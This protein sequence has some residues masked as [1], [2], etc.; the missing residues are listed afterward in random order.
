MIYFFS[1]TGNSEYVAERL[2]KGPN[3][4]SLSLNK[5]VKDNIDLDVTDHR[6]IIVTPTYAWRIPQIVETWIKKTRFRYK[7]SMYFV[8]TCGDDIGNASTYNKELCT[9]RDIKYM[10]TTQVV[11]PENYIALFDTPSKEEANKIV[12][13]AEKTIDVILKT[14]SDF[15]EFEPIKSNIKDKF[16]SKIVNPVFYAFVINDKKF[17][18]S[19]KCVGCGKCAY[20]CPVNNIKLVK[21]KPQW[22]GYC[23]HCMA[24]INRCPTLAID[25]G[26]KS[27]G[28]YRYHFD[29]D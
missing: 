27:E 23:I 22:K 15:Q 6:V 1:G 25:Y 4:R 14:I 19:D 17:K 24:C 10:G 13:K 28:R 2:K 12:K 11:M 7:T 8:M 29:I 16:V 5:L 26:K 20:L 3:E 21:S 18:V 9:S